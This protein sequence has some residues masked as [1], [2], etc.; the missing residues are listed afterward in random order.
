MNMITPSKTLAVSFLMAIGAAVGAPGVAVADQ[1]GPNCVT[2]NV[3]G[4]FLNLGTRTRTICDTPLRPDGSWGR[5]RTFW[6]PAHHVSAQSDCTSG[7]Y[8]SH[9]TYTEAHDVD[10]TITQQDKYDVF[11]YNVLPD[12]PGHVPV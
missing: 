10:D 2:E 1:F 6:I 7:S 5:T 4:G 9:C 8:S 11:P 12:E 3:P